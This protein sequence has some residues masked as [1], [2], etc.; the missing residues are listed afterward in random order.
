MT[1]LYTFLRRH[2][3]LGLSF[4]LPFAIIF[5]YG[6]SRHVFPFGG[7]TIMTVDLGQQYIDFFAYF[8][9]T[10]L[11]HPDT[12]FYSFAKGLGGDMLGVWA[13][14]LMSP[15]NLLVLLTPG[16]WLSFGVWLM[17]LLKYGFSGLSFA[18]ISRKVVY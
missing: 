14:Y 13:Y 11:Q 12:F 10:L 4:L 6:L 9:T 3:A 2:Y 7:Q 16:K 5:I 8:R 17:V 15:F 18:I 1:R